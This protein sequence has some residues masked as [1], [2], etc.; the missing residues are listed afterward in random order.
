MRKP[1]SRTNNEHV[2][3]VGK[4]YFIIS[5]TGTIPYYPKLSPGGLGQFT[6]SPVSQYDGTQELGHTLLGRVPMP[7]S[8]TH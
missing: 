6:L 3:E 1:P 7:A 4:N 5:T 8:Y 2:R